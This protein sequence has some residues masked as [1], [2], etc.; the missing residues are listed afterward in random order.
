MRRISFIAA[1]A[2]LTLGAC[3]GTNDPDATATATPTPTPTPTPA[4]TPTPTP[5]PTSS[6][7]G[8]GIDQVVAAGDT[9]TLQASADGSVTW[10]QLSGPAVTLSDT[11]AVRPT[12]TAPSVSESTVLAFRIAQSGGESDT[13]YVE[14]FVAPDATADQT[15]LGDFTDKDGWA[16][17][18][19][20]IAETEVSF[21][22]AGS[23]I[24]I[25]SNGIARHATGV[26]SNDG[27]PHAI[28]IQSI[29]RTIAAAP[30]ATSTATE[31]AEFGVTLDGVILERDTAESYDN[32]G[33]WNYEAITP[34]I[35]DGT[36][37]PLVADWIG[38]DCS[39]AHVQPNGRY[40]YH[41]MM[42]ALLNMLGENEGV[43]DM[44]LGGYAADGFPFYLRYGYADVAS[45]TGGL[46][47]VEGSWQ[48]RSG[49]RSG[50]PGGVYDGEFRQDWEYVAGSGDLDQCNG[51]FGPTPEY[52]EGIY[53]Y[54]ITDDYPYI[55]RCV[56]GTPDPSFRALGG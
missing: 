21:V 4:P 55:P 26:F 5:T 13:V 38:T 56:F 30:V 18:V 41:G 36:D 53:H 2:L 50:G 25:T 6:E 17:T 29:S 19:A 51:R 46:V 16:C 31:M 28:E 45:A 48:L 33:A 24:A 12:F 9:V 20:P 22:T 37:H 52:P 1:A 43:S 34:G 54:Y 40:H 10:S 35:A 15:V 8:G 47:R 27:N 11:T 14:V 23:S 44:I 39:N 49:T 3:G 7:F 32:A 42:E